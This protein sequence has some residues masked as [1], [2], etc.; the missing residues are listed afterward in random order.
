MGN[1][2]FNR[3]AK[4][5]LGKNSK[6]INSTKLAKYLIDFDPSEANWSGDPAVIHAMV[7]RLKKR[8]Q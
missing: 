4:V 6:N 5:T 1:A 2:R 7:E 3:K 8:Q